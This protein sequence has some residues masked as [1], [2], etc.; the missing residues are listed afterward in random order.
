MIRVWAVTKQNRKNAQADFEFV[1]DELGILSWDRLAVTSRRRD[2][3]IVYIRYLIVKEMRKLG[4]SYP[5]IGY[6]MKRH[7]SSVIH[8]DKHKGFRMPTVRQKRAAD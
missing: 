1:M 6:V 3:N 5:V 7:H 4:Y 2:D 8:L